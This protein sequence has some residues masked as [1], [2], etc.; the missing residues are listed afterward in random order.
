MRVEQLP[1]VNLLPVWADDL[2][3]LLCCL[4]GPGRQWFLG[5]WVRLGNRLVKKGKRPGEQTGA[6]IR[7]SRGKVKV[8]GEQ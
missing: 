8:G 2:P 4:R 6:I 1:T 3:V 5:C 7:S